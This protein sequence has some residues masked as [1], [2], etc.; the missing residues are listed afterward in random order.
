[1]KRYPG[2]NF[3]PNISAN[4]F[5]ILFG[6]VGYHEHPV[7]EIKINENFTALFLKND[8]P[9]GFALLS[10][11]GGGYVFGHPV[12]EEYRSLMFMKRF[13]LD[14]L[15]P[16]YRM[17]PNYPMESILEDAVASYKYLLK[18]YKSDHIIVTGTSAGGHLT[19]ALMQKIK[20]LKLGAPMALVVF[21]PAN[22]E[23]ML[24][25]PFNEWKSYKN[26]DPLLPRENWIKM[27]N[28]V[29]EQHKNKEFFKEYAAKLDFKGFSSTFITGAENETIL[30][31]V[32]FYINKLKQSGVN[33]QFKVIPDVYHG[34][35]GFYENSP[36]GTS[37]L[38]DVEKFLSN[39]M[40][41]K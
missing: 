12:M 24:S 13:G 18:S 38:E 17:V 35:P 16:D 26:D 31:G 7:Q 11:H 22:F 15:A 6:I 19:F 1:M 40:E 36:E 30:D 37:T 25:K 33:I 9:S 10:F 29:F 28:F 20:E 5:K 21:S 41:K 23:L 4:V 3:N 34:Y 27:A 8:K 2:D 14:A 32:E 39:I